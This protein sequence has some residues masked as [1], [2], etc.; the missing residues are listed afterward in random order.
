MFYIHGGGWTSGS[1]DNDTYGP[2]FLFQH[3]D[4]ILVTI[5][6]RLEVLGF[7]SLDT[8]EVPGNAGIKDQVAALKWVKENI[9]HFGGDPDNVTIFGESAGSA[10]VSFHMISP[11]SK[12][13][14]HKAIAQS[15][16]NIVDWSNTSSA[17]ERAFRVGKVL[18]K[19]TTDVNE[20]LQFLRS[21]PAIKLT[22]LATKTRTA[23]EKRRGLPIYF[24]P[25]VE[26]K[27]KNVP[28]FI[29][30]KPINYLLQNKVNAIPLMIGY[31]SA[32][33]LLMLQEQL[34]KTKVMN[35]RPDY[36]VPREIFE[37]VPENKVNEMGQRIKAYYTNGKEFGNETAEGIINLQT[38]LHFAYSIHR[39]A[40]LYTKTRQPIYM[41]RFDY[42][43]D[44]NILKT[45]LNLT[46]YK[47]ACHADDLF[48]LFCNPLNKDLY[49]EQE[50]LQQLVHGLTKLWV[51]FART[52]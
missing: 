9:A 16:V 42:E 48:Y 25:V 47:G 13:L 23:D 15:G 50:R 1:G 51:D 12:G 27:F 21:V 18:G 7:L 39:F 2:E 3:D 32:E 14:F 20:L 10:A 29:D 33:G 24:S 17:R 44:L 19:D 41:Y 36:Y 40:H 49:I 5:N 30:D 52:G 28:A 38:D 4:V 8:P 22:K 43:S 35:K 45:F 11:L 46:E 37:K 26:K 31:N 6:Y 34:N